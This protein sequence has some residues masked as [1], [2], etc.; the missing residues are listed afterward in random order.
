MSCNAFGSSMLSRSRA[1]PTWNVYTVAPRRDILLGSL[2]VVLGLVV[3]ATVFYMFRFSCWLYF[4]FHAVLVYS[5]I[6]VM[7]SWMWVWF[8][9][10]AAAS[11]TSLPFIYILYF[12]LSGVHTCTYDVHVANCAWYT[13]DASCMHTYIYICTT[14]TY[15]WIHE[16][17][18]QYSENFHINHQKKKHLLE[19]WKVTDNHK[20][21]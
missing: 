11:F 7:K 10:M 5:I 20:Y 4:F 14:C 17:I 6:R 2:E 9:F 1:S 8:S 19:V 18:T 12:P 3:V 16:W 13:Y 21:H 15:D